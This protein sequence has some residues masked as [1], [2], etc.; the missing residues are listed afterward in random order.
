MPA[1]AIRCPFVRH[2]GVWYIVVGWHK[3]MPAGSRLRLRQ[4]SRRES[5]LVE[6]YLENFG[7]EVWAVIAAKD[8]RRTASTSR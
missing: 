5:Q 7:A 8:Q 4:L 2:E 3:N 6:R 1:Q